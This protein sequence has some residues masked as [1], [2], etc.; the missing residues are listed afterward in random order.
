VIDLVTMKCLLWIDPSGETFEVVDIPEDQIG[1]AQKARELMIELL[2]DSSEMIMQKFVL[3]E[4]PSE[5]EIRSAVREAALSAKLFPVFCG[6]ALRNRGV[7]PVLDAIVDYLP[8]PKDVPAVRGHKV[9]DYDV[10][11]TREAD[12]KEPFC[13]LVFKIRSDTYVGKLTYMR[14]YSGQVA[15][16]ETALNVTTQKKERIG[17]LLRM[18]ANEREDVKEAHAGDIVAIVGM[19]TVRTGDTLSSIEHPILLER[20]EFPEPVISIAIEPRTKADQEKLDSGLSRLEEED[21]TFRL[22]P[23]PDTGQRIISGMGELHLEIIVDR[24]VREFN[25]QANVGKPQ[26]AYKETITKKVTSEHRYERQ[27]AGKDQFGH[28]VLEMEPVQPGRGVVRENARRAGAIPPEII[29][30]I[31]AGV[32]DSMEGGVIAG[33]R[34][35]DVKVALTGGTYVEGASVDVAYRIAANMAFR[36][37]AKKA[38]PALLEPVMKLEIISP[39]EYTGDI[40]SDINSRRGRIEHIDMLGSLKDIRATVPLSEVFG[41][42]TA[43]RSMSQGRATHTLQFSHYDLV[44]GNIMERLVARMSGRIF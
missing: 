1:E 5:E 35:V 32:K 39:D 6:S 2:A 4:E 17:R 22:K 15:A 8:S 10:L 37:G 36:E 9:D 14:V 27:V 18:H 12:D 13:G 38:E 33:Y 43:V 11:L 3:G 23:D 31:E 30:A 7:Q 41:Y 42:A 44:P 21:P 28:V 25:V 26:V 19:K 20:M 24:L 29:P 16:G 34:M 40:I